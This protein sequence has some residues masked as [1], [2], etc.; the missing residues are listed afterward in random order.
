MDV[1]Y[2]SNVFE[3]AASISGSKKDFCTQRVLCYFSAIL[4]DLIKEMTYSHKTQ[5]T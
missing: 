2:H 3:F 1:K 5:L 4:V